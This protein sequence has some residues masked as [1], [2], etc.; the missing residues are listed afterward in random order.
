M[1]AAAETPAVPPWS[2]GWRMQRALAWAELSVQEIADELGVNRTTISR[3]MHDVG[4]PPRTI[5]LRAW[6]ARCRVPYEW[7]AFGDELPRVDSNHQPAGWQHDL[8]NVRVRRPLTRPEILAL[9]K[10]F[11]PD[12]RRAVLGRLADQ[13]SGDLPI[14]GAR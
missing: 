1:S 5:Y 4:A 14:V 6:A 10:H 9:R 2:L 12:N 13:G 8:E 11:G 7:L 3:W